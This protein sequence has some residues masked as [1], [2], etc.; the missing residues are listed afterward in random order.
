MEKLK[1]YYHNNFGGM[2]I[3]FCGNFGQLEP[4]GNDNKA[5]VGRNESERK[6]VF[7]SDARVVSEDSSNMNEKAGNG[8]N[9]F[10]SYSDAVRK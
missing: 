3:V 9:V 1:E 2:N 8:S 6:S 4:I 5:G 10:G 7:M